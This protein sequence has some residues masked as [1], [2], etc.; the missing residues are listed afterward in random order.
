MAI[1]SKET[2]A[3]RKHREANKSVTQC[4]TLSHTCHVKRTTYCSI[5][6][7]VVHT[8][9][10]SGRTHSYRAALRAQSHASGSMHMYFIVLYDSADTRMLARGDGTVCAMYM[11]MYTCSF[12]CAYGRRGG[13]SEGRAGGGCPVYG[14]ENAEVTDFFIARGIRYSMYACFMLIILFSISKSVILAR[15]S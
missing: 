4:R 8:V 1:E 13:G 10:R 3:K 7:T 2:E 14:H 5:V 11:Y 6:G 9:N 15:P 12:T